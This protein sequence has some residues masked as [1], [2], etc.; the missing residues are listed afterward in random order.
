MNEPRPT[1]R[2]AGAC[3]LACCVLLAGCRF[4]YKVRVAEA[5]GGAPK[6]QQM[7]LVYEL[8]GQFRNMPLADKLAQAGYS[9][10][11]DTTKR[12]R[13]SLAR[14]AIQYPHPD[15]STQMARATL[16]LS[17]DA[18]QPA[19]PPLIGKLHELGEVFAQKPGDGDMKLSMVQDDE[20]WV[21]DFPK[22]QLDLLISDLSRGGFF[23]EQ[24]RTQ[25]GT[26]L[27]VQLDDGRTDKS[28]TPEPRLDDF[29]NRVHSE[30]RLS[31][32]VPRHESLALSVAKKP[33]PE[34]GAKKRVRKRQEAAAEARAKR[35]ARPR[36]VASSNRPG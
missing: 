32:F 17:S 8:N 9:Q 11:P 6:Y 23:E 28:W 5:P 20:I 35:Q 25:H 7:H 21:L 30:G 18:P 31:G 3:W 36:G 27:E 22:Q 10:E 34:T 2:S 1:L 13:W 29:V 14:L 24:F 33:V 15:G 19:A 12:D 16:R 26:R 4:S